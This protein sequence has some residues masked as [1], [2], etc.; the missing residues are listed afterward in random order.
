M[1]LLYGVLVEAQCGCGWIILGVTNI[2]YSH[3]EK[4]VIL[5]RQTIRNVDHEPD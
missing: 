4:N 1:V 3:V 2:L 5:S